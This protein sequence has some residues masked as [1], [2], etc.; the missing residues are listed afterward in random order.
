MELDDATF[1]QIAEELSKRPV[2]FCLV[3]MEEMQD[4]DPEGVRSNLEWQQ[5]CRLLRCGEKYL[6]LQHK[7]D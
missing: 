2:K 7:N 4:G 5:A 3:T 1:N 6:R